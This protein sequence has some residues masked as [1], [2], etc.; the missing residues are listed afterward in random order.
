M[1]G[2]AISA[3]GAPDG[4]ASQLLPPRA[5]NPVQALMI[6][7]VYRAAMDLTGPSPDLRADAW[8]YLYGGV[9]LASGELFPF[10]FQNVCD[11]FA[12]DADY[13]RRLAVRLTPGGQPLVRRRGLR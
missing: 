6:G 2:R 12:W 4:L 7:I 13:L 1:K 9:Q 8:N 11:Y 5:S 10:R 3:A